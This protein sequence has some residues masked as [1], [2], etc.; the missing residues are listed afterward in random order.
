MVWGDVS[1]QE[2]SQLL[3]IQGFFK[4]NRYTREVL[5]PK[6]V[7]F[8]QG[9]PGAIFQEDN[10]RTHNARNVPDFFSVQHM[11][12][13]PWLASSPDISPIKHVWDLMVCACL[14]IRFLQFQKRNFGYS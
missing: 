14:G 6:V 13:L 9:I 12:L 2:Q 7:S 3:R 1:Y 5:E 11:Q 8:L 10:A 4:C